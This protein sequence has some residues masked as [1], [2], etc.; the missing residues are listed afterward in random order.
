EYVLE[1]RVTFPNEPGRTEDGADDTKKKVQA[2]CTIMDY[3]GNIVA[4]VGGAGEKTINR[5][6]NRAVNAVR[7]P[8]SS[9]KP[10]SVYAPAM[11][12]GLI[13]YS[14]AVQNYALTINGK[15]WP[16]NFNDSY[17]FPNAWVTVQY[18][19]QESLNTCAAQVCYK[20]GTAVGMKYMTEK[21]HFT[22]LVKDGKYTDNN[23]SS[24]A[25]GGMTYGVNTL[26]MAAAYATFGNQGTY[27]YPRCYT[28]V[29]DYTGEKVL[30]ETKSK[31]EQALSAGV[32]G[33]MNRVMQT[34]V[35]SGTGA[36]NGVPGF[37]SYMKTGTTSDT[38]D[39]WCAGGTPYYVGAVW[40]G[41]D[42]QE[43]ITNVGSSNPA[44]RIWSAIMIR[45]HKGLAAKNF[46]YGDKVV[47]KQYCMLSG[48]LAGPNCATT[49]TGYYS[50]DHLPDECDG[51]HT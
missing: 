35:T 46:D 16:K 9:V 45:A 37:T 20:L 5:G 3:E 4:M 21:F 40:Y 32:A 31:S 18:A 12:E 8:G 28:K 34:V 15:Q 33:S 6:N 23:I 19:V 29:T 47:A 48:R 30:L 17:G 50:A 22:T 10:L 14:T 11:E 25:V 2:A 7:S 39:K 51:T 43:E 27:Y 44:A 49:A 24:M 26:E 42:E 41:Y 38:K 1:K 36:G 13:T